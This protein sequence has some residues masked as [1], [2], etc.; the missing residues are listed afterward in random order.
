M[1]Y[2]YLGKG[3]VLVRRDTDGVVQRFTAEDWKVT[4]MNLAGFEELNESEAFNLVTVIC[5]HGRNRKPATGRQVALLLR[6]FEMR[7]KPSS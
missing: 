3:K 1:T 7:T 4:R 5:R 2:Q 6:G